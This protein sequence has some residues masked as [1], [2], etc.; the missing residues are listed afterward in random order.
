M[1]ADEGRKKQVRITIVPP[2]GSTEV[3]HTLA[4]T[5]LINK[6]MKFDETIQTL[7]HSPQGLPVCK[8]LDDY[9]NIP[10]E[11]VQ[12]GLRGPTTIRIQ[13]DV[14]E[15][16]RTTAAHVMRFSLGLEMIV[17]TASDYL[18]EKQYPDVARTIQHFRSHPSMM[19]LQNQV[20]YWNGT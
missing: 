6:I 7:L 17:E 14:I 16:T 18:S 2:T 4:I 11:D 3:G 1:E 12:K 15:Q 5:I 8:D 13:A 20:T 10:Q 9:F 19:I